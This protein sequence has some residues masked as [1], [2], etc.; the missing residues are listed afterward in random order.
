MISKSKLKK[1]LRLN[2]SSELSSIISNTAWLFAEK[3]MRMVMGVLVGAW[4]ARYLG[5]SQFGELAYI[6]AFATFF[7]VIG[8][9]GLDGVAIRNLARDLNSVPKTLG[10]VLRLRLI[11]G[12]LCWFAAVGSMALIRPNDAQ[13]LALTAI[14]AG[15]VI[16]DSAETVDL[17]FQSQL[18]SKRTVLS[19]GISYLVANALKIVLI[20][21]K[22]PLIAFAIIT[23]IEVV[24]SAFAFWFAYSTYPS[25]LKWKWDV[26]QAIHLLGESWPYLLSALAIVVYMRIDQ[27]MLKEMIGSREVGIYSVALPLS[28]A[29][30]F[31]PTAIC[32]SFGPSIARKKV[33]SES[34]YNRAISKL[35]SLMWWLTL[36]LCIVIAFSATFLTS[37][38]YGNA[39]SRSANVLAIHIFS[40]VPVALGVAQSKWIINEGRSLLSL[41]KTL[42]GAACNLLLNF[43]LIPDYGA[44]GASVATVISQLV[45]GF[46]SNLLLA[47]KVF[48]MQLIS[49]F[50]PK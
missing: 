43:V 47:P 36:P 37:M 39:Y 35:F 50:K 28:T 12:L 6:I 14:V 8:K 17:W 15:T 44:L 4:V 22:A 10:T 49:L 13:S 34:S 20:L 40:N 33:E 29:W 2:S 23:L 42:L 46:L 9:L 18:Q 16:F 24:L 31:I 30:Y 45:S 5:P 38:L 48:H 25:S 3:L 7:R 26:K 27:I 11:T 21:A 32:T 41:Y 19:K 1:L